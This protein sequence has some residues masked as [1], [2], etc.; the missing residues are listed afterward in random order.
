MNVR[1]YGARAAGSVAVMAFLL[2]IGPGGVQA[3]DPAAAPSVDEVR[4]AAEKRAAYG[5]DADEA[6]VRALLG[7]SA[8][9]GS[10]KWGISMTAEEER[11]VDL[12]GRM[13]YADYVSQHLS[14]RLREMP[15]YAGAYFDQERGGVLV[16]ALTE[17]DATESELREVAAAGGGRIEFVTA[18]S[19]WKQLVQAVARAR[20]IWPADAPTV[21]S[22]S[23]DEPANGVVIG[24]EG[25]LGGEQDALADLLAADLSVSVAIV[26]DKPSV[27]AACPGVDS[28]YSPMK[29][30]TRIR[31]GSETGGTCTM[32]FHI[33]KPGTTI[34]NFVTAGHCSFIGST[35][36]YMPGYGY[37]GG[38]QSNLIVSQGM[39]IMRVGIPSGQ[40]SN[41]IFNAPAGMEVDAYSAPL[42]GETLCGALGMSDRYDCGLIIDTFKTWTSTTC[43][44]TVEGGRVGITSIGGDSGSPLFRVVTQY[45]VRA[46]GVTNQGNGNFARY[47]DALNHWGWSTVTS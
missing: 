4:E 32:G 35:A 10:A 43:N 31:Q 24:V 6:V 42:S 8:D 2:A 46:V 25:D 11:Q 14:P 37:I 34:R 30:G 26:T 20:D 19:T 15:S 41:G 21:H 5:L 47:Y 13:Q 36:W 39:D 29:T 12:M 1:R 3:E 27:D 44:C 22:I 40:V 38:V 18:R 7:S 45:T 23:V 28:C 17:D 16:V 9:V 33:K